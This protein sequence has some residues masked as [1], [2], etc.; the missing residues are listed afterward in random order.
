MGDESRVQQLVEEILDSQRAPEE[1]CAD[2][3]E[4]L[5]EVRKRLEQALLVEAELTAMFPTPEPTT[6][7]DTPAPRTPP[8]ELPHIPGYQV[9]AV[10]GR[11]GRGI[12]YK[13]RHLRLNRP[14]AIK[15]LLA[16]AY[17]D[18]QE[19]ERFLR[20]AEAVAGLRHPNLVQVHDM[21]DHNGRPYFTMEYVEGGSLAQKL[22]GTP[23]PAHQV[24]R[25]GYSGVRRSPG[26]RV[27]RQWRRQ[28]GFLV[29]FHL[30]LSTG[31]E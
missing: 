20:E 8:A 2:C 11:G 26:L 21:G 30:R 28:S 3:P 15:M 22:L 18:L 7:A 9:E 10:L 6:D 16:G 23:Q 4:R 14:V 25:R 31:N 19:R 12:V 29:A 27:E 5:G 17:A 13:A 1:V 24:D